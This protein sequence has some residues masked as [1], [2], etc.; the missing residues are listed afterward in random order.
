MKAIRIHKHG[1]ENVLQID[2]IPEPEPKSG[3]V[4][5]NIKASSLNHMDLWVREGISGIA[6]LPLILGCDGSGVVSSCGSGVANVV[7]GD[8]VFIH[9]VLSCGECAACK[10]GLE[11][12]CRYMQL[13]GEHVNGTHCEFICVPEKNVL[14]LDENISFEEAAAFPLVY[15][16]AW[17]MLVYNGKVKQGSRV[18]VMGGSGGVGSAAIQI[19]K[20]QGA[21]VIA[22][23][24]SAEKQ[25]QALAL[26]ADEV[27]D[28]YKESISK[29]VKEITT[30]QGVDIIIEHVGEKVWSECLK[31]LGMSGSL[32][33]C[34][35]TSGPMITMDLRHLFIKQQKI[36][37]STMGNLN[38]LK[39]I[40]SHI[41]SGALKPFVGKVFPY[42]DVRKAH[43]Y[44]ENSEHF[45]KVVLNW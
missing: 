40:Y 8:R 16:T 41:V 7:P 33:T 38:E 44:L 11:N 37:G 10:Q 20:Q 39:E 18:L 13:F 31:A 35:A 4:K 28:H 43:H 21:F 29:R 36:I 5:I 19:A 17:H 15:L 26:G 12:H 45:G 34:G 3:D 24:G 9:P 14:K 23:A 2:E 1:N 22:T 27:I 25:R 32:V 30:K 42:A 6:P